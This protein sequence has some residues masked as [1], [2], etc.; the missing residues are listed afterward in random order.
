LILPAN[1]VII[2]DYF[3]L[4]RPRKNAGPEIVQRVS[5]LWRPILMVIIRMGLAIPTKHKSGPICTPGRLGLGLPFG[6][7]R[8]ENGGS[9]PNRL[10]RN[11]R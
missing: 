1:P 2:P 9:F 11:H 10:I 7:T 4:R 6:E 3:A 8:L 5:I